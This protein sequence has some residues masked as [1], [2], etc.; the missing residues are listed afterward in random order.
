M[1]LT[2]VHFYNYSTNVFNLLYQSRYVIVSSWDLS[3]C[4]VMSYA[5]TLDEGHVMYVIFIYLYRYF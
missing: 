1:G 4:H 3:N 5:D 2:Q